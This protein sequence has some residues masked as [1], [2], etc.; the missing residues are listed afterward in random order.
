MDFKGRDREGEGKRKGRGEKW[1]GRGK[2]NE[3]EKEGKG[4]LKGMGKRER[5]GEG[6]ERVGS[7]GS[8]VCPPTS[9]SW[10]R[11]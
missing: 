6:K 5:L 3:G 10:L 1:E 9:K 2:M 8:D 7:G 11:H 4:R